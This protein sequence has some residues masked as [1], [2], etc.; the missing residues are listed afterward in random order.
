MKKYGCVWAWVSSSVATRQVTRQTH[1]ST[2]LVE[3]P[4][5][6]TLAKA[7]ATASR[8]MSLSAVKPRRV[9]PAPRPPRHLRGPLGGSTSRGRPAS[10]RTPRAAWS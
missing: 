8:P 1:G 9:S 7:S 2:D 5:D 3:S 4:E 6:K 10:H